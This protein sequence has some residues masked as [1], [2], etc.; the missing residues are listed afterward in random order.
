M[1]M[2][3]LIES[4]KVYPRYAHL[5]VREDSI[6]TIPQITITHPCNRLRLFHLVIVA[7][8]ITITSLRQNEKMILLQLLRSRD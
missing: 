8:M 6:I 3:N 4:A 2:D 7:I 1:I 5:Q